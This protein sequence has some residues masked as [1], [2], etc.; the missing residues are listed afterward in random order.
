MGSWVGETIFW[1]LL[2][3]W[4]KISSAFGLKFDID[5]NVKESIEYFR[6]KEDFFETLDKFYE[7]LSKKFNIS[8]EELGLH[9]IEEL[10]D[11]LSKGE[12]NKRILLR[13]NKSWSLVL[14]NGKIKLINKKIKLVKEENLNYKI[15]KGNVAFSSKGKIIGIVGKDILVAHTTEPS[16]TN[17]MKKMKAIITDEGGILSHAAIVARE[18]K[19]P[20]IVGTKVATKLIKEGDK[21]EVDIE[22]GTVKKI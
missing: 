21:V 5:N 16:M 11:S 9:T 22:K 19:I 20:C 6:N 15:I 14:K 3:F 1:V 8:I 17:I 4:K 10:K 13:K 18:F 12:I 2:T 7:N